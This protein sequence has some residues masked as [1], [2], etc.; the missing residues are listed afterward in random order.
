MSADPPAEEPEPVKRPKLS[1]SLY[2]DHLPS[3]K[4]YEKSYMHKDTILWVVC[5]PVTG[6]IATAGADGFIKFWKKLF[7]GI[8]FAKSFRAHLSPITGIAVSQDGMRLAT[9]SGPEHSVKIF[10][11]C[12]FDMI[13]MLKFDFAPDSICFVHRSNTPESILAM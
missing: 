5:S 6:F 8:E 1:V 11:V 4:L 13:N 9:C 2:L 3:C 12:T 7:V 10:D